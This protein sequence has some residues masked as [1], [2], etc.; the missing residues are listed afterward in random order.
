MTNSLAV[1]LRNETLDRGFGWIEPLIMILCFG[2][3]AGC[4]GG[5]A[6][7]LSQPPGHVTSGASGPIQINSGTSQLRLGENTTFNA[8]QSGSAVTGGFWTVVGGDAN[9]TIAGS[10]V[11]Q[12]PTSMP[13]VNQIT[14]SFTAEGTTATSSITLLNPVPTNLSAVPATLTNTTTDLTISGT[15]FVPGILVSANGT[16]LQTTFINSSTLSVTL[17]LA[18]GAT[19]PVSLS[20]TN[21]NPGSATSATLSLPVSLPTITVSPNVLQGGPVILMISGSG[22]GGSS[23]V[24]MDGKPLTTTLQPSGALMASGY[25]APWKSGSS[26]ITV[27]SAPGAAPSF[28]AVLPIAPTAVPYDTASRFATQAAFG[29]RE[30]VIEHIQQVG[31]ASF[32]TEQISTPGIQY[33]PTDLGPRRDFLA[34]ATS[35]NA[36]LRS[37]VSWALQ[38]FIVQQGLYVLPELIPW[39]QKMDQDAFGNFQQVLLDTSSDTSMAL[40][41]SLN[42]NVASTNPNVHPNQNFGRELMQLFSI[43]DVMLN[44]DGSVQVDPTGAA[45]PSYTQATVLDLSRV[46]T[47]WNVDTTPDPYFYVFGSNYAK[48]LVANEAQHDHGQKLLFGTV[49]LPAGQDAANDRTIALN[50]IFNHQNVPPYVSRILIQRLV[51]SSPSPAYVKRISSVFKNDGTGVRGNLAAVVRAILL[52]PEAR[53]GDTAPAA[54]DGFFQEPLL[55]MTFGMNLLGITQTD[56]QPTYVPAQLG[57]DYDYS[58]TVF[59]YYS[60]TY[61]IPGTDINSPEFQLLNDITMIRRSQYWW[62]MVQGEGSGFNRMPNYLYRTFTN[63]PDLVDGLNHLLY[64]GQMTSH[65]QNAIINYCSTMDPSNMTAQFDAAVFLAGNADSYN[66]SR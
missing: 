55:F 28:Q 26:T 7:F 52:D 51:K 32:I 33:S 48:P 24:T 42:G 29:P 37:R 49:V 47:G 4:G 20:V 38:T 25:L 61:V 54:D 39:Q 50:A 56:D 41:L 19:G 66:V 40:F 44:D 34:N 9:G 63:I 22:F 2:L 65:V 64:H 43:G 53:I 10:G 60:P 8:I 3:L 18:A 16:A 59:G 35:G 45:I 36:L 21:P 46:F 58:K 62:E 17:T 5:T 15:G 6:P 1:L 12:T 11:Y 57:E 14:V 27:A 31:L 23:V 30:D 13:T